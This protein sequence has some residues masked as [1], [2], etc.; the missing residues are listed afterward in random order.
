[1]LTFYFL[2]DIFKIVYATV[3]DFCVLQR[4]IVQGNALMI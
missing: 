3:M 4:L 2:N 1:M